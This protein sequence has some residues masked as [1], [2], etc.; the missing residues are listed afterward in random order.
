MDVVERLTLEAVAAHSLIA[1][2]HVQRYH[3]AAELCAGLR[4][5]DLCCG[6]GYGSRI[7]RERSPDV[8]GVDND[9]AAIDTAQATLGGERG[10]RFEVA[11]AHEFLRRDLRDSFDAIVLLEGL[12][13][14][15]RADDALDSLRHQAELGMRLVVSVPNSKTFSEENPYHVT[16]YDHELA[17]EAFS[18][19]PDVK[20]LYQFLA[21]G[22]LIRSADADDEAARVVAGER[23]EPEYANHFI[24]CVNFGQAPEAL[25]E[26]GQARLELAPVH[27]RY[28]LNLERANAELRRANAR[29]ARS[30]LGK[31]DSAAASLLARLEAE[32]KELEARL[33]EVDPRDPEAATRAERQALIKRVEEL[34][35][36]ALAQDR[37]LRAMTST[38]AWRLATRFWSTRDR[39]KRALRLGR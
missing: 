28:M 15:Q 5:V 13:H 16:D 6:T 26:W 11:D 12:E 8:L 32:R 21:E 37:Q 31:A 18:D 20:L 24:A 36:Q 19:F 22:S 34:H 39:L 30:R 27:N 25:P 33:A 3:L 23:G 17:L 29:L 7:L 14:L 4:V 38:R 1:I 2:E 9:V 35:E 10:P